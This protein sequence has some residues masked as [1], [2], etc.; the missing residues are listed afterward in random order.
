MNAL[1]KIAE[2]WNNRTVSRDLL[3]DVADQIFNWSK[4]V[5]LDDASYLMIE[6][7]NGIEHRPSMEVY[8]KLLNQSYDVLDYNPITNV[9]RFY[10][11]TG[12]IA[13][14]N[15]VCFKSNL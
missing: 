8:L 14:N 4:P 13:S 1:T 2:F 15:I 6:D 9:V 11:H 7:I 10:L 5:K 3:I 12:E